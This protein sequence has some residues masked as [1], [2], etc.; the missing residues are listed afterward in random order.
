[1]LDLRQNKTTHEQ[2]GY[3]SEKEGCLRAKGSGSAALVGALRRRT[4]Q[5]ITRVRTLVGYAGVAPLDTGRVAGVALCA[6]KA[7]FSTQTGEGW[8]SRMVSVGGVVDIPAHTA[9]VSRTRRSRRATPTRLCLAGRD[10]T[11]MARGAHR[12]AHI[13][14][15]HARRALGQSRVPASPSRAVELDRN[16]RLF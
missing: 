10:A 12:L 16:L 13:P 4:P 11:A 14:G 9:Q 2:K 6:K 3:P 7:E 15:S 1:M 8:P 5:P